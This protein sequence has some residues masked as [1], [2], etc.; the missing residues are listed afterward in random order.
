[1]SQYIVTIVPVADDG[2]TFTG[3]VAQTIVRIET[4]GGRPTLKEFIIRADDNTAPTDELPYVDFELLLRAFIEPTDGRPRAAS[5]AA[6]TTAAQP[7]SQPSPQPAAV[8]A[9]AA[10]RRPA[11]PRPRTANTARA[12]ALTAGRAYRRA[13]EADELEAVY[14][15]L[16]TINSVAAHFDVP[17]HT[18]QGWISRMRRKSAALSAT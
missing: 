14:E 1:M 17:V 5:V 8:T 7:S 3:P 11:R 6:P 4:N 9:P 16:G 13:P 10:S 18:A 12:K 2:S 15:Q